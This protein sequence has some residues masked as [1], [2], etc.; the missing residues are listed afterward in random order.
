MSIIKNSLAIEILV[1]CQKGGGHQ[2]ESIK[3]I[4]WREVK[5][6]VSSPFWDVDG[7]HLQTHQSWGQIVGLHSHP[8]HLATLMIVLDALLSNSLY[9]ER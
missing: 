2:Q 6:M 5:S 1:Y 8:H 3:T 9:F 7:Q 4:C